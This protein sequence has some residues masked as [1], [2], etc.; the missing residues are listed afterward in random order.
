MDG[1]LSASGA[2]SGNLQAANGSCNLSIGGALKPSSE[3]GGRGF[4]GDMDEVRLRAEAVSSARIAAE[5]RQESGTV[6]LSYDAVQDVDALAP[7]IAEPSVVRTEDGS[8]VFSVV[9][10]ENDAAQDSVKC[11]VN[12]CEYLMTSDDEVLPKT[13][14]VSVSDLPANRT[15]S[16]SVQAAS[17]TGAVIL[18]GGRETFYTGELEVERISD[19]NE[20]GLVPG[21]LRISRADS[22]HDLVVSFTLG[23][24]A[25]EGS[26][27]IAIRKP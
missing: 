2:L 15:F 18:L 23:G 27:Y 9:V 3:K 6:A 24:S 14:S 5:W 7:V 13:Y 12:G 26:S 10:S 16:Y 19:G 17:S 22:E 20:N 11:L 8:F 1:V 21:V 4:Y 25:N